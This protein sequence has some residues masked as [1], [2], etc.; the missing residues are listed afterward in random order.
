[1]NV[2]FACIYAKGIHTKLKNNFFE[3]LWVFCLFEEGLLLS[4]LFAA[5]SMLAGLPAS[6]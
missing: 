2:L 1:M 6:R 3:S 4:S 5:N